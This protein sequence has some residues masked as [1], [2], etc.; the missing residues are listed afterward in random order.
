MAQKPGK[1]PKNRGFGG[2]GFGGGRPLE[3]DLFCLNGGGMCLNSAFKPSTRTYKHQI[4]DRPLYRAPNMAP[5]PPPILQ[6]RE[7]IPT[8]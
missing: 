7:N 8:E 6:P 2:P 1:W 4:R 3:L 5:K